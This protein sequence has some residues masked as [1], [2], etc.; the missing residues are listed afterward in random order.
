M[1]AKLLENI[2][3]FQIGEL[4]DVANPYDYKTSTHNTASSHKIDPLGVEPDTPLFTDTVYNRWSRSMRFGYGSGIVDNSELDY[5]VDANDVLTISFYLKWQEANEK[6]HDWI[7]E[8]IYFY[9]SRNKNVNFIELAGWNKATFQFV[10]ITVSNP[11][12]TAVVKIDDTVNTLNLNE[13]IPFN[14]ATNSFIYIGINPNGDYGQPAMMGETPIIDDL[15]ITIDSV[16]AADAKSTSYSTN[17]TKDPLWWYNFGFSGGS[18][19][20]IY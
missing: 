6:L 11:A 15:R 17:R 8:P 16:E 3:M 2:R 12:K 9:I 18:V 19:L 20:R 7:Q 10:K 5:T 13:A 4:Y 1:P 14:L